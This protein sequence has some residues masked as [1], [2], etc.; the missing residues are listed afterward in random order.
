ML[1]DGGEGGTGSTEGKQVYVE[2]SK[3]YVK[4]EVLREG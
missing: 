4:G 3:W 1:V 2:F